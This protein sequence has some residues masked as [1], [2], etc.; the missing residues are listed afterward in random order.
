[1]SPL[2]YSSA[3]QRRS[4]I[5]A[6]LQD[7]GF[8]AITDMAQHLGVSDMTVRRDVKRLEADGEVRAV[9]GGISLRHGTLRTPDFLNRAETQAEAKRMLAASAAALVRQGDVIAVDSGT[10]AYQVAAA[11]PG[12]FDGTVITNSI[13]VIQ[14]M[15]ARPRTHVVSLGG[16]LVAEHQAFVGPLTVDAALRFR[17][18][19]FFLGAAAIDTRGVYVH[20]ST[21]SS[22]K[23]AMMK[24][25]DEV[26]LLADSQKFQ[27]S[28]PVLLCPLDGIHQLITDRD[29]RPP[30]AGALE[31]AGVAY[32]QG[33]A[34][35]PPT[36]S[37]GA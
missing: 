20:S 30:L 28:A 17:V 18:R 15:L 13:P 32:D 11:L 34:A 37:R 21:E 33:R 29:P 31:Q 5:L 24:M 23:Q 25:A 12:D 2:R 7:S 19:V 27:R 35:M 14:L 22:A 9:H 8:A 10:T 16:D 4:A 36:R 3:P 1:M 6:A 26:V